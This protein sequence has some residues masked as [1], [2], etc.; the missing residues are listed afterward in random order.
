MKDFLKELMEFKQCENLD[1]DK[2]DISICSCKHNRLKDLYNA[3]ELITK[4]FE[5]FKKK[6]TSITTNYSQR[7]RDTELRK[8]I[9]EK[10]NNY[11]DIIVKLIYFV[12]LLK[13]LLFKIYQT[14]FL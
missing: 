9:S 13:I 10:Y 14:L 5:M 4:E 2:Y 6:L 8:N 7:I 11:T 12:F 1:K 3:I